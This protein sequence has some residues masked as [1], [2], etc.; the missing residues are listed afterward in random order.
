MDQVIITIVAPESREEAI[1][2]DLQEIGVAA[3]TAWTVRGAGEHG[4]RPTR[5]RS[6]NVRIDLFASRRT[7]DEVVAMLAKKHPREHS[8]F[9]AM[10][11]AQVLSVGG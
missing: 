2:G 7:A 4:P 10:S 6:A 1:T 8:V 9:V 11:A 5:W 3:W